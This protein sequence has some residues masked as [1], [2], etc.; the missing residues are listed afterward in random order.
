[1]FPIPTL[2][3]RRLI[4]SHPH[5]GAGMQDAQGRVR[6]RVKCRSA[7]NGLYSHAGDFFAVE[8]YDLG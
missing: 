4:L 2:Q 6:R 7:G 3:V 5:L 8:K 1:M